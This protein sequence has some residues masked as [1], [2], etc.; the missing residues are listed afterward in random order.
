MILS[1]DVITGPVLEQADVCIIGSGSAGSVIAMEMAMAG[2]AVVVLEEGGPFTG[3]DFNKKERD[4]LAAMYRQRYSDDLSILFYQANCLGGGPVINMA[5]CVRTPDA[6]FQ[7]WAKNYGIDDISPAR[8]SAYFD[9]AEAILKTDKIK[10]TQL[11]RNN[12]VLK[13]GST[14]LGYRGDTFHTNRIHCVEC[15]FCPFGCPYD[16]KHTTMLN[17]L[18]AALAAGAQLYVYARAD[19]IEQKDG[20]A[21]RVTGAILNPATKR[22]KA[23]VEVRAKIIVLAAN[24]INS[25]QILLNSAIGNESG[26]VGKNLLVQPHTMVSALFD[27]ELKGYRGIPQAYF[28]DE[29]EKI[30]EDAGLSGFRLEGGFTTPGLVSTMLPG[31]GHELKERMTRYNNM[32]NVVVLVYDQPCGQVTL[33]KYGRPVISYQMAE[34]TRTTMMAGMREAAQ[35]L[36][37][38]GAR[39]V[40]FAHEVPAVITDPSELSIIEQRGIEPC[41]QLVASFHM[42]GTCRMGADPATSV[43]DSYLESHTVKNLFV[44]DASVSPSTVSSHNMLAIMAIAH[45]TAD[46]I[47]TNKEKYFGSTV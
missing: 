25:A 5:D 26:L 33:N 32:A 9:K 7:M 4:M 47:I 24:T 43:V 35:V 11:N 15:G 18:P 17:Y 21:W 38:A 30:D 45:R 19:R 8:M 37:A 40:M 27:E 23:A 13:D 42:Q 12:R 10:D 14:S 29:F 44:V 22:K 46:Y 16:S 41:S 31:F 1:P 3:P 34:A 20:K 6:V 28:C 2:Y 36:F 39:E